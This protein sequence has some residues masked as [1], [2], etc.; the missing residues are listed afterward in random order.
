VDDDDEESYELVGEIV[1]AP[2]TGLGKHIQPR[3]S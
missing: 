3:W 1:Q 2:T